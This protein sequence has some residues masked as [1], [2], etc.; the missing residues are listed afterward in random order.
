M[1]WFQE[2]EHNNEPKPIGWF[3]E[4]HKTK[5]KTSHEPITTKF[6]VI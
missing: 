2:R 5:D 3:I 6:V 1:S 4:T